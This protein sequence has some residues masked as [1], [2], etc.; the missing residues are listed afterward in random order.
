MKVK[1][2][3][4]LCL[5]A[6]LMFTQCS[7]DFDTYYERP[8]WLEDPIY[9]EL[10]QRG[11]FTKYLEAVDRTLH[12]DVLKGAGLYTCFAPNDSAFQVWLNKKNYA[13]VA[14]IPQ[15][16]VEDLVAYSLVYSQY[17]SDNLGSSL[18][19]K[20]WTPGTAYKYKTTYYPMVSLE[21]KNGD[22]VWVV[23]QNT[24]SGWS[25]STK[26]YLIQNYKYLPVYTKNFFNA[27]S[28][29]LT[30]EDYNQLYPTSVWCAE[31]TITEPLGNVAGASIIG[32]EHLAEN[33]VFYEIGQVVDVIPNLYNTL[34][35]EAANEDTSSTE[36]WNLLNYKLPSSTSY[37][38]KSYSTSEEITEQYKLIY[39]EK[40][41]DQVYIRGF[42]GLAVN[43]V[44]EVYSGDGVSSDVT[45][46]NGYTMFIPSN[47]AIQGFY[48]N[49]LLKY[50]STLSE[51]PANALLVFLESQMVQSLV[52]PSFLNSS[53]NYLGEYISGSASSNLSL[54]DMGI[55]D[56]QMKSNGI[57]YKTTKPIKSRWFET[58]YTD[59]FLNP[60]YSLL[61]T[62]Y[63]LYYAGTGSLQEEL[64][65][66]SL[67][68]ND[69]ERNTVF[70]ISDELLEADGFSY[71]QV[72]SEFDHKSLTSENAAI[73]LKRLMKNHI[74]FGY[75]DTISGVIYK[76]ADLTAEVLASTGISTYN[77]WNYRVT[78]NG[79]P[80]RF[81]ENLVQG[82]GDIDEGT[83]VTLTKVNEASNGHVLKADRLIKYSPTETGIGDTAFTDKSL[84]HYLDQAR[85][86]NPDDSVFVNLVE[87]VMKTSSTSDDLLGIKSSNFYTV[88][89]PNN[90]A[91]TKAR[92]AGLFPRNIDPDNDAT[93]ASKALRFLQAHF[94]VGQ[95][96]CDDNLPII[97]PLSP[98][99]DDPTSSVS[100]TLLGITSDELEL[101]NEKTQVVAYKYAL[102]SATNYLYFYAKDITRGNTVLVKGMPNLS[103]GRTNHVQVI[104]TKI[105]GASDYSKTQSNRMACKAI[106]HTVNNYFSFTDQ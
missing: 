86:E 23:D 1:I 89:M 54:A 9:E 81:K 42:A 13:T 7:K 69:N 6:W 55:T 33:G 53:M 90:S 17:E 32:S 67:N 43:P 103:S 31:D 15:Q 29:A 24:Q 78:S 5:S 2:S 46:E 28:P 12:A 10:E 61:N 88:L 87:A 44:A 95:V 16:E 30:S 56:V 93:G 99:S 100:P 4:L 76:G 57:L 58:V 94:L 101:T 65:K 63:D 38:F 27:S 91:M 11:N 75:Q 26:T 3:M 74:F 36:F 83:Y 37:Y 80:I 18:V 45:Q 71:D 102:S 14:D 82:V 106:L 60:N 41:I 105:T 73:R 20:V 97:Y 48:N 50:Y 92:N 64:M 66:C 47:T 39:P 79:E 59:I 96:F 68:G 72:N 51:V 49:K 22:S 35:E 62:A 70:L 34:K 21:E 104:R 84:W 52:W 85:S 40:G 77:K 98:L 8:S 25:A 19:S